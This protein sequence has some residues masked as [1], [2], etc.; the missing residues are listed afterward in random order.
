MENRKSNVS[1]KSNFKQ[2]IKA[3]NLDRETIV[4][5]FKLKLC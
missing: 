1:F 5:N 3:A 4:Y 2:I